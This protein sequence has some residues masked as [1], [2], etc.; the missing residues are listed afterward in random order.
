VSGTED[1]A[2]EVFAGL[3]HVGVDLDDVFLTLENEGVQKFADSW[4]EVEATFRNQLAD[5]PTR[6]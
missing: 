2:R 6:T 1:A 3:A 5:R 4:S